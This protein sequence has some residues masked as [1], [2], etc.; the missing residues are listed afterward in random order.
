[1][2]FGVLIVNP[3][4][5]ILLVVFE[6]YIHSEIM[7]GRWDIMDDNAWPLANV[8]SLGHHVWSLGIFSLWNRGRF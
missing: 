4:M 7:D 3:L 6:G 1:M 5:V 8:W 2:H